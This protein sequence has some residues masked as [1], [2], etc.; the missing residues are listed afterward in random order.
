MKT[1]R[2]F[3]FGF[4]ALT[5]ISNAQTVIP[6]G[7]VSGTWT[8]GG[9]PY[10]IEGEIKVPDTLTL[11]IEP[12]VLVE[13]QGHYKFIVDGCLQA[14][15]TETDTITFTINDTTGFSNP[16]TSLGGWHGIRFDNSNEFGDYSKLFYCKLQYGKAVGTE[17]KDMQGG[18][19][20]VHHFDK[21]LISH[22]LITNNRTSGMGSAGGGIGASWCNLQVDDCTFIENDAYGGG[23]AISFG[24][25]TSYTGAPYQVTITNT[26]FLRNTGYA[27]GGVNINNWGMTP[28]II[29]VTIENCEFIDNA[30]DHYTGLST[31]SCNLSI[32]NCV[33]SGN[34]AVSYTAAA[35]FSSGSVVKI[36]NC[37]FAS[38]VASTGGGGWNSGG[39]TVWTDVNA[40]IMNCTFINNSAEYGAGLTVG[41]GG[42]ASITNCIFWGN[43][44]DQIALDTLY[45]L[46]GTLTVNYCDIQGGEASVNIVDPL[47]STL[48]WGIG[49][50]D[51]NP[52]FENSGNGDYHLQ[53][54]SPC[55][56]A[57]ITAI[58]IGGVWHFCP[59]DDIEGNPRP[60]PSGSMPDMGA[61]E[62]PLAVAGIEENEA[63]YPT[64][65][66]LFQNYPNPF[67]PTTKINY[68][69]PELSF[70]IV[71][72]YDVLSSEVATLVS[73]EKLMGNYKVE[74][75]A[76]LL[77]SGVYFYQLKAGNYM[78][79]KKMLLL[80]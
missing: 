49:N 39:L 8:I 80:R 11:T 1:L 44:T 75:D 14:V 71:K 27:T 9:S 43:S 58:Q 77:P 67:N 41:S 36:W 17:W 30:S 7:D 21:L 64:E 35:G 54:S 19:I 47:L 10:L 60:N 32:S 61:Y 6:A 66:V 73:E 33:F 37:L 62:S 79:T 76:S 46:G 52:G 18:A 22:C 48:N 57:G 42:T 69:I 26:N 72:V 68:Q 29:D 40:D 28:L 25:D 34:T 16:D 50:I 13:F 20:F 70:V 59:T 56:G 3:L 2:L 74:F 51:E 5:I 45:G 65:Y 4:F 55:I 24:A 78:D 38:N 53:N 31:H 15:G 23:G 12:G 63:F